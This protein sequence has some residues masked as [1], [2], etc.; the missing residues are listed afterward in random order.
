MSRKRRKSRRSFWQIFKIKPKTAEGP[1]TV[2]PLLQ[3]TDMQAHPLD[4]PAEPKKKSRR[5]RSLFKRLFGFGHRKS[6]HIAKPLKLP[7][8]ENPL[9]KKRRFKFDAEVF[10]VINSTAK[11]LTAYLITYFIYSFANI[12]VANIF[13]ISGVLYHYQIF[14]PVGNSSTLW[15][16]AYKIIFITGAGPL[17]LL[18]IGVLLYQ[19]IVNNTK[20]PNLKLFFLWMA[21]HS[22]NMFF[23]A[24]VSGVITS[25]GFGYVALWIYMNIVFKILF[26]LIFLFVLAAFGYNATQAFLETAQSPHWGKQENRMEFLFYQVLVSSLLG[27]LILTLVRIPNNPPYQV[28]LLFAILAATITAIFNREAKPDKSKSF[29]KHHGNKIQYGYLATSAF[30]LVL[31]RWGLSHGL[32]I[33]MKFEFSVSLFGV[34]PQVY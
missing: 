13:G 20:T 16:P 2:S 11:F 29:P 22:L 28:I 23:G 6:S 10:L 15:F 4:M 27:I 17:L 31:F 24:F 25:D 14:W 30:L 9:K 26:S 3:R 12:F 33:V 18:L 21:F 8:E 1:A 19:I 7:E 5:K 32:H 34:A